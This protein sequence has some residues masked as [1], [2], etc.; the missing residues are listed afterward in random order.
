MASKVGRLAGVGS[1]QALIKSSISEG[2]FVGI[3][4]GRPPLETSKCRMDIGINCTP[5][6]STDEPHHV[7]VD[8]CQVHHAAPSNS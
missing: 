7:L 4:V 5:N 3:G 1:Q 2:T 6:K 8:G